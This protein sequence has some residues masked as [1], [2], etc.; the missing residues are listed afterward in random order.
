MS[1]WFLVIE[2]TVCE[3]SGANAERPKVVITRASLTGSKKAAGVQIQTYRLLVEL[4][5]G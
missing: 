1:C 4:D 2:A 3:E 5:L